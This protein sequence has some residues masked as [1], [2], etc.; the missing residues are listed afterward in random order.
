LKKGKEWEVASFDPITR[1][2]K[3]VNIKVV[4]R[5]TVKWRDR[6]ETVYTLECC[7]EGGR[8]LATAWVDRYGRVLKQTV[9]MFG[10]TLRLESRD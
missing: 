4:S 1:T 5:E 10:F 6:E 7:D 9:R 2:M 3:K 8:H